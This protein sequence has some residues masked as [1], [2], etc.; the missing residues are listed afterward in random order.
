MSSKGSDVIDGLIA[1]TE[2]FLTWRRRRK[3]AKR[4]KQKQ[5][6]PIVD[7]VEAF[8]W[9]AFVVLLINQY[10][11]QA[12]QIPST[13]MVP[14]L[15]KRDRIFV[16]K[17]VYGPE[18]IPGQWK[19]PGFSDP[20]RFEVIIFENPSYLGRGPVFDILQRIIYMV[21]L[22]LV[23]IDRDE[24]G[25]PRAHFLIKRAVGVPGDRFRQDNGNLLIRPEGE[26]R[27]YTEAEFQE[28]A[29]FEYPVKRLVDPESYPAIRYAA[30]TAAYEEAG[31][32]VLE[33]PTTTEQL[34]VLHGDF[35][36]RS[37]VRSKTLLEISPQED[38]Y[39]SSYALYDT[40]WYVPEGRILP[41]GDNRD[42]SRDGRYFGPVSKRKILGRAMFKYW[43]PSR[44]GAIR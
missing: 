39:R 22:S 25:Q 5:K 8:I 3:H 10:L 23:D 16:N 32:P 42:N 19:L 31:L 4:E 29:G 1:G 17:I 24:S 40:G 44:I 6:N 34:G 13:S 18:L 33:E 21:T 37:L 26:P 27:W 30:R 38:R 35:F 28:L 12:Y 43:P 9:A 41:L 14:T 11:L 36:E 15:L 20:E 2:Q 7:W